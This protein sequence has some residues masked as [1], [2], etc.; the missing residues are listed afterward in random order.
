MDAHVTKRSR[1]DLDWREKP[2]GIYLAFELFQSDAFR[3][4][5]KLET[6]LL[7]FIYTRRLYPMSKGKKKGLAVDYWNPSNGYQM[8]IPFCAIKSF[9]HK[10]NSMKKSA[11]VDSTITRAIRKLMHV[12]FLS[13]VEMGGNGKGDMTVYR[14]ENN[15]RIWRDGDGEC[16][17]KQGMSREKG[18][19]SPGSGVFCPAKNT[20]KIRKGGQPRMSNLH[21]ALH[22][23]EGENT[24]KGVSAA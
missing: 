17:T 23:K 12:G 2:Q 15:W 3:S 8:T 24:P 10:P 1:P 16:F 7:L 22:E 9:F 11:P 4:L 6:D 21:A 19:C 14:L 18:F 5:S 20:T 13:V